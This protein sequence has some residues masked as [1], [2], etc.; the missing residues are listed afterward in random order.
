MVRASIVFADRAIVATLT[1]Q[2]WA[3]REVFCYYTCNVLL[4]YLFRIG[5]IEASSR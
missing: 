1:M 3:G 5:Q 4:D 2:S